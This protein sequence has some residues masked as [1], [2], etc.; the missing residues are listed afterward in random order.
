MTAAAVLEPAPGSVPAARR[1]ELLAA[2]PAFAGLVAA[3]REALAGQMREEE[4][5]AG[6][7]V[8]AEGAA[9]DRLYVVVRGR[10]EVSTQGPQGRIALATLE[11]GESFGELGLLAAARQ[12]CATVTALAPLTVLSLAAEHFEACVLA[13]PERRAALAAFAETLLVT[14]FL[15][16][17]TPFAA[18]ASARAR[19]LAARLERRPMARG[20]IIV[21]EGEPGDACFLV[22]SG[23]VAVVV[24]AA[25]GAPREVSTLGPG[26]LFGE[27]ALLTDAPRNA[28]V[29]GLEPGELLVLRRR[30][31]VG[32]MAEGNVSAEVLTL[33][34][35]RER[36]RQ[37][38]GILVQTRATADGD[39]LTILKNPAQ[40]TYFQLSA[41]G[42]FLW[43][44]MDGDHTLRDLALDLLL[45]FKALSPQTVTDLVARLA[46]AGF[47]ETR[48]LRADVARTLAH[49]SRAG[50]LVRSVYRLAHA[51]IALGG[52]DPLLDRVYRAFARRCY[53]RP[54]QAL[55]A[56]TAV[57][58]AAAF[59][60]EGG[61]D[62]ALASATAA[63][64]VFLLPALALAVMMHEVAH[65]FTVK[66]FGRSVP[67][68]G[69]GL[70]WFC[71]VAF[72]E[73]SDM[74]LERRWPR[75][76][77]S[78]AGPYANVV[79][80]GLAALAAAGLPAGPL[81]GVLWQFAGLSF[82]LV[83][84]N[85]CPFVD[86][87]GYYALM[88]A[89][90]RPRLRAHAL[91]ALRRHGLAVLK[92]PALVRPHA[93]E[94]IFGAACL[95]YAVVLT[96]AAAWALSAALAVGAIAW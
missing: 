58:G 74:W 51:R 61:V 18:L 53:T 66:A 93:S 12:R 14:R 36:P 70:Y 88:D 57:A 37:T 17:A 44:L 73:T 7:V 95:L 10:A 48:A 52:V 6:A 85:L 79:L 87:D 2:A 3:E 40:G 63:S 65:A 38:R 84:A 64:A 81:T 43:R 59:W 69:L 16:Q 82:A 23:R 25:N 31:L 27:A 42:A 68:V 4:F 8:V 20:E 34:Q 90:E 13:A 96:G 1:R 45:A 89:L 62:R 49:D 94:L 76:A 60:L 72:V 26:M 19:A 56:A 83:L 33:L 67:R 54:G 24:N 11:P 29:A 86:S 46:A 75:V 28:T 50:R 9:A 30:D 91:A 92:R 5:A 39:T 78:L 22:R 55:L 80:A 21:R 41:Q 35:L 77:V 32:A 71:P 47:V 15:K